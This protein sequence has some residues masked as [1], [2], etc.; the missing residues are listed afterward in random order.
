MFRIVVSLL[1]ELLADCES[2]FGR[3]YEIEIKFYSSA[4]MLVM[5]EDDFGILIQIASIYPSPISLHI[6]SL[7][8][9]M[10][11]SCRASV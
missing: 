2:K 5:F 1:F 4:T 9:I 3:S 11:S 6:Q 10:H 8:Y 7:H